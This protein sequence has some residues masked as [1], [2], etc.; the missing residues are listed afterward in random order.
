MMKIKLIDNQRN[1]SWDGKNSFSTCVCKE[2]R[3]NFSSQVSLFQKYNKLSLDDLRK[4]G[5]ILFNSDKKSNEDDY[6]YELHQKIN[7][8]N[9]KQY[10]FTTTNLIGVLEFKE[11]DQKVHVEIGSRFSVD[12]PQEYFLLHMLSK[13]EGFDIDIA[14]DVASNKT[15]LS[16]ILLALRF[17]NLMGEA[18]AV[19]PYK[20]YQDFY[21]NDLKLR[22]KLDIS[23]HIK[24]NGLMKDKIAYVTHE[25]TVDNEINHLFLY[26]KKYIKDKFPSLLDSDKDASDLLKQIQNGVPTF[27]DKSLISI[28]SSKNVHQEIKHPYFGQF[29][30]ELRKVS[31][32][33]L[34]EE[35]IAIYDEQDSDEEVSGIVLDCAILWED[36]ISAL[37]HEVN[38]NFIHS[39]YDSRYGEIKR[40]KE[41]RI[42]VFP[43]FR[44]PARGTDVQS[45]VVL[46]T[47][48]KNT[49]LQREDFYQ[50]ASY[51]YLT[52]AVV[53]GL[54]FPP[55]SEY[56]KV[57]DEDNLDEPE[58]NDREPKSWHVRE[59]NQYT[60]LDKKKYYISY[61]FEDIKI[62]NND[63]FK[64][65]IEKAET[66]FKNFIENT[67]KSFCTNE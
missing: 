2:D 32:A 5:V 24:L 57:L 6:F 48:F 42:G 33:L 10:C 14:D 46:D 64:E 56:I 3:E 47:K 43:D 59:L 35:G 34:N 28:L 49:S 41:G 12:D 1:I 27:G 4:K 18:R 39:N 9:D 66:N 58:T 61:T 37:I 55:K 22:G 15:P 38:P 63:E 7:D 52:G 30:D 53:G 54:I 11:N 36:Y 45:S 20:K 21:H 17:R 8:E 26:A 65:G 44:L 67:I 31:L 40:F 16:Q 29:Y 25:H 13:A 51:M 50:I 23:R 60:V 62:S 19:G